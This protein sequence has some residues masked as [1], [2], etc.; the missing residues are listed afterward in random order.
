MTQTTRLAGAAALLAVLGG[1]VYLSDK[2]EEKKAGKPAADTSPKILEIPEDQIAQVSIKKKD[3]EPVVLKRDG[4]K[5]TLTAPTASAA[6]QDAARS[7]VTSLSSFAS[8]KLIEEKAADIAPFGL[9]APSIEVVVTKKDGKTAKLLIGD[10]TPT[11]GGAFAKTDGDARIFS[12][13]SFNK[14][15]V[16]KSWKDLRDKRLLTVDSDQIS[17]VE[18]S[19]K[20]QTIELGKNSKSEWTII[21][22]GPYRADNFQIEELVRKLKD[23][24]MDTAISS[25]DAAKAAGKFAG[26]T[27][28]GVARVTDNAGT[29]TLEIR[30]VAADSAYYA[31]SS[32]LDGVHKVANE[33][34]EG[35][36]KKLEDFRNKK[37]FDFGFNE[38]TAIEVSSGGKSYAFTKSGENWT[39]G[40]KTMDP[41]GVQSLIDKARDLAALKFADNGAG[42][43]ALSIMVTA[44]GGKAEKVSIVKNK[45]NFHYAKR[46]SEPAFYELDGK[47]ADEIR[48]AAMD[49]KE[50]AAAKPAVSKKK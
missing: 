39:A 3:G 30:K 2:Q 4:T 25:E 12:V 43:A 38:L 14:T 6:D 16:D 46:E 49:V 37:L 23:A 5:W 8:D 29:Q 18:L 17:R 50:P 47:V 7:L 41:A 31:K 36:D 1:L 10:D 45:D 15:N 44:K 35:L 9:A 34:G 26:G 48:Q 27:P 24:K 22:P 42:E 40:G 13:A 21:K 19:A 32:A 11:G 20:G 33:L 28:V